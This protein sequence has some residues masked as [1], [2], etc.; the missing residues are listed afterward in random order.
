MEV[1][2][3]NLK[4]QTPEE[5]LEALQAG[6]VKLDIDESKQQGKD[7]FE[8]KTESILRCIDYSHSNL[9]PEAQQLLLCLAP[10]T[11]V[12]DTQI[13]NNYSNHLKQQPALASLPFERWPEV[14]RETHN[15]GLLSPDPDIPRFLR[16]QPILPYFLRNRLYTPEQVEV[17]SAIEIA[18]R[19][20]YDEL[21]G[22]L[23]QLLQSKDPKERQ[24]GQ[25]LIGLE[26]ENLVTALNL[27]LKA[28]VPIRNPYF[29]LFHYLM[30]I[31]DQQ[32]GLE[33]SQKVREGLESYTPDK[34]IGPLGGNLAIVIDRI[35]IVQLKIKQF[36]SAKASYESELSIWE[37]NK[38]YDPKVIKLN[39]ASIYHQLGKV[40][41]EQRQWP[42]AEA[43][44]QRA[45][46]IYVEFNDRYA[47][48]N[49]YGQLGLLAEA[50]QQWQQARDYL[51]QTL[52]IFAEYEDN[53]SAGIVL[54][55]LARLW[56]TGGDAGIPASV[57]K[58][59]GA[60]V[61]ETEKLLREMLEG[62][63]DKTGE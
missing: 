22:M 1:V 7:I 53:Y 19:E 31:Q 13:L 26:Y 3:A 36:A 62:D 24:V 38:S 39:V 35:A 20:H 61:E 45:L 49:T 40:A 57:A 32:R 54:R 21:G 56:K 44:Y 16:L 5:I 33:L 51:L 14:I 27:A 58:I 15:W 12:I 9:S 47:Q 17:R 28:Q 37:Q 8:Q 63:E 11:S 30:L 43:Y 25:L 46:Q 2:L 55:S 42:Q 29:A 10:F 52:Q 6:D 48:S 18:F 23:Y 34:L 60:S 50:Q 59:L 41:Q 4:Q